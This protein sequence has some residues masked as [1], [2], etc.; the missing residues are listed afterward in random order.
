MPADRVA[1]DF[2]GGGAHGAQWQHEVI[3]L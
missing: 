1:A 2:S 3:R